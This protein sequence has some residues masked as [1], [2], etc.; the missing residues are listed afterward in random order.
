MMD[1][2]EVGRVKAHPL[3]YMFRTCQGIWR[4][5]MYCRKHGLQCNE[6]WGVYLKDEEEWVAKFGCMPDAEQ[7]ACHWVSNQKILNM[8]TNIDETDNRGD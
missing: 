6:W 7:F 3:A 1:K 5:W 8:M 2:Y 4:T